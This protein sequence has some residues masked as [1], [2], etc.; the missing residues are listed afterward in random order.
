MKKAINIA[1]VAIVLMVA[2]IGSAQ[3]NPN[4]FISNVRPDQAGNAGITSFGC[5][6]R[7]ASNHPAKRPLNV[8]ALITSFDSDGEQA[9]YQN[10]SLETASMVAAPPQNAKN[11]SVENYFKGCRQVFNG[12]NQII[13]KKPGTY[14]LGIQAFS[15]AGIPTM[16]PVQRMMYIGYA[17]DLWLTTQNAS[18]GPNAVMSFNPLFNYNPERAVLDISVGEGL[19]RATGTPVFKEY[20]WSLK[21]GKLKTV[22]SAS[23]CQ[24]FRDAGYQN[25]YGYLEVPISVVDMTIG[26]QTPVYEGKVY[27]D[28]VCP[29]TA[30]GSGGG[31]YV[32]MPS[33]SKTNESGSQQFF[34]LNGK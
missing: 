18:D 34:S 31:G 15:D 2:N 5:V 8:H 26:V 23:I 14:S 11:A 1:L 17:G 29:S 4:I 6:E 30:S 25:E 22:F 28:N 21:L 27:L 9:W 32:S 33:L 16:A 12:L 20:A 7:M 24:S 3:A 10:L 19:V 13:L